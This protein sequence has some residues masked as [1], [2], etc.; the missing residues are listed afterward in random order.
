[1][2]VETTLYTLDSR[3]SKSDDCKGSGS[4]YTTWISRDGRLKSRYKSVNA[5][6][7]VILPG[8]LTEIFE[9]IEIVLE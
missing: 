1:M 4:P 3:G 5:L 8:I 7:A 2:V 9:G 6:L